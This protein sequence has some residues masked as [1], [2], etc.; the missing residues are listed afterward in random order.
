MPFSVTY[1]VRGV[2]LRTGDQWWMCEC[3]EVLGLLKREGWLERRFRGE[4]VKV[5]PQ[6]FVRVVITC[7]KCGTENPLDI[8]KG[9]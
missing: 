6:P 5:I 2:P 3:G 1:Q 4:R 9:T 7:P 8:S